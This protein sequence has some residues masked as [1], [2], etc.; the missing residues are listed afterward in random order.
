M[1]DNYKVVVLGNE[2]DWL[3]YCLKKL[4]KY[5][6]VLVFN[7]RFPL[8]HTGATKLVTVSRACPRFALLRI[9]SA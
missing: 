3:N 8:A 9:I 7:N 5:E 1:L 6:N 4:D 2:S